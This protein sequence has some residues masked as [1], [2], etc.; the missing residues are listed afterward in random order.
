MGEMI[1]LLQIDWRTL[2]QIMVLYIS[3]SKKVFVLHQEQLAVFA[4]IR[5]VKCFSETPFCPSSYC[6]TKSFT[7]TLRNLLF[8]RIILKYF[9][10]C[11]LI[12]IHLN[13]WKFG[14]IFELIDLFTLI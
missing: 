8:H 3:V 5:Q 13:D 10:D 9:S 12:S 7:Y 14:L 2:K 4:I 6:R 11:K 1:Y